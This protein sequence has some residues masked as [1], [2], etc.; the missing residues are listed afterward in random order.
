LIEM[1]IV[2]LVRS[3]AF[4]LALLCPVD[5]FAQ[6][7]QP[8]LNPALNLSDL[9]STSTALANL[10]GLPLAGGTMSGNLH[11]GTNTVDATTGGL[12]TSATTSQSVATAASLIPVANPSALAVGQTVSGTNI[13]ANDY[14]GQVNGG[15]ATITATAVG[16]PSGGAYVAVT[17]N[18]SNWHALMAI[19]DNTTSGAIGSNSYTTN[20]FGAGAPSGAI[21]GASGTSGQTIL[22]VPSGG[23]AC[24]PGQ[25]VIDSTHNYL[26][27]DT[28][29]FSSTPTSIQLT[30][31]LSGSPT[32]DT[33]N[34]YPAFFLNAP[35]TAAV[36]AGDTLNL[37]PTFGLD[38]PT[39][40]AASAGAT[41]TLGAPVSAMN[42]G[43]TSGGPLN[44]SGRFLLNGIF[45]GGLMNGNYNPAEPNQE[46]SDILLGLYTGGNLPNT[47]ILTVAIGHDALAAATNPNVESTVV[48]GW[49]GTSLVYASY[50]TLFGH[51][52]LH[53]TIGG[54]VVPGQSRVAG[55]HIVAIGTDA[56]NHC[57][58][59]NTDIA[60]GAMAGGYS[61][62]Y[63]DIYIGENAGSQTIATSSLLTAVPHDN[64]AIGFGALGG[65]GNMVSARD[66][67]AIGNNDLANITTGNGNT[68][69][70]EPSGTNIPGGNISTGGSNTVVGQGA[71]SAI[72]SGSTNVFLGY[73]AGAAVTTG[74]NDIAIGPNAMGTTCTSCFNNIVMSIANGT[75]PG[76]NTDHYVEIGETFIGTSSIPV[77]TSGF[78]TSPSVGTGGTSGQFTLTI[79]SGGTASTGLITFHVSP[80][81]GYACHGVDETSPVVGDLQS[82]STGSAQISLTN[83]A[84]VSGVKTATPWNAGD[85]LRVW[86]NG[87]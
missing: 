20:L 60:I 66:N 7:K 26:P 34:C 43:V 33:I 58:I 49:A 37:S 45:A 61:N 36:V 75:T 54:F 5:A 17:A 65:G 52:A 87:G 24:L 83:Y 4:A 41:L 21:T 32:S 78:G 27:T 23:A 67:I 47:D 40:G 16:E 77:I 13:P 3:A 38:I 11:M 57:F 73:D 55:T 70:G 79:G 48:G 31:I 39:T 86:C 18:P 14:V 15:N 12:P 76:S 44:F 81:H 22:T 85:V 82:V 63:N 29:V 28:F 80:P 25:M 74:L 10:G 46:N 9:L 84:W 50:D 69:V 6:G 42:G 35:T 1:N 56:F 64:V 30:Q 72:S 68:I 71:G 59:C 51:G 53:N 62:A 2:R 19:Q 8:A